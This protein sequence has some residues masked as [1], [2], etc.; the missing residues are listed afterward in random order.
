MAKLSDRTK[1]KLKVNPLTLA[2]ALTKIFRQPIYFE[3][4]IK[5]CLLLVK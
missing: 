1:R 4:L 3:L 5:Y 2:Y